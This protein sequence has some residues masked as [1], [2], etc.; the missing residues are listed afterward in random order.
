MPIYKVWVEEYDW[1]EFDSFIIRAKN[2]E[3]AKALARYR[4]Y[5]HTDNEFSNNQRKMD[6]QGWASAHVDE[7]PLEGESEIIQ[8]SF[9]A[10]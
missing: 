8:E 3:E 6:R 4:A 10:G 7:I 1:D 9:N 2:K 5:G